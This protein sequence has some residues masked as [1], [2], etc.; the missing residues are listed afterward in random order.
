MDP[1]PPRTRACVRVMVCDGDSLFA[2]VTGGA[3]RQAGRQELLTTVVFWSSGDRS[4][5]LG[6]PHPHRQRVHAMASCCIHHLLGVPPPPGGR[7]ATGLC[8]TG[9]MPCMLGAGLADQSASSLRVRAKLVER[10]WRLNLRSAACFHVNQLSLQQLARQHLRPS[11]AK[12]HTGLDVRL[13]RSFPST[14]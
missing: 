4:T 2:V 5:P 13:C 9:H 3:G 8:A 12:Q 7:I 10:R 1:A 6:L 14:P 11:P